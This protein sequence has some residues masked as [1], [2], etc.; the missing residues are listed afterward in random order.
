MDAACDCPGTKETDL[1]RIALSQQADPVSHPR[2]NEQPNRVAAAA[3]LLL[4]GG[5][6]ACSPTVAL[7]PAPDAADP[8]CAAVSV[9]LP[10]EIDEQGTKLVER[11]TNAQATAAWGDPAAVVLRCGVP[12]PPPTSAL[13][14]NTVTDRGGNSVDWLVDDS[15]DPIFTFTTYGRTPSV[16]VTIDYGVIGSASVLDALSSAVNQLPGNG[17]RCIGLDDLTPSATPTP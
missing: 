12:V 5:L 9:R 1:G 15:K 13:P 2:P 16:S 6:A 8:A 3:F 7:D 10:D 17:H 14:C 11:E 4:V